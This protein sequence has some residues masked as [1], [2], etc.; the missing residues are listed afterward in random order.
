MK[1]VFLDFD[2]VVTA[3]NGTPGSYMTHG[4]GEYGPTPACVGRLMKLVEDS[5]AKIVVSSNWRKFD[6][7]GPG[8]VW[9]N[10]WYGPVKNPLPAFVP[11]LGGAYIGTL[12]PLRLCKAAV[13]DYWLLGKDEVESFVAL[14]DMCSREGYDRFDSFKGRY[15]NTDQETG[16]TDEDCE[17]A[18]RILSTP[19]RP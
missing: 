12:P 17:A 15:V 16:L 6:V 10:P 4:P 8:S 9:K 11:A 1:V 7:D 19:R 2:G 14:D 3:K 5:G 18:L 13:A